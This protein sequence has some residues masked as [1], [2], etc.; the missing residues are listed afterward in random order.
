MHI[1]SKLVLAVVAGPACLLAVTGAV[2]Q[3]SAKPPRNNPYSPSPAVTIQV[4]SQK[5]VNR[6]PR[7]LMAYERSTDQTS[8]EPSTASRS[9][10]ESRSV[11]KDRP[12]PTSFY[13][14]GNGDVLKITIKYAG[15][16][17]T[18]SFYAVRSDG[19]IDLPYTAATI[20]ASG[21]TTVEF[22]DMLTGS[23]NLLA[24]SQVDVQVHEFHSHK[25]TLNG[26]IQLPGEI[27][28]QRE[29][30]PLFTIRAQAGVDPKATRVII[31][32]SGAATT[33]TYE[34]RAPGTDDVLVYPGDA[35]EFVGPAAKN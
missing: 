35:L 23:I 31:T 5:P 34:L 32:R 22:R 9:V 13:K 27:S 15:A 30:M 29:A 6:S 11:D 26:S 14:I 28:L 2:C 21:K 4:A 12:A 17:Q 19:T 3:D 1:R 25:I 8:P 24:G 10:T 18:A 7:G 20:S 16:G 33:E